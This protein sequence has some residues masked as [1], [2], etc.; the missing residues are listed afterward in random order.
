MTPRFDERSK[1]AHLS[2]G[3]GV[4]LLV[5]GTNLVTAVVLST[6]AAGRFLAGGGSG[7]KNGP[8]LTTCRLM[9]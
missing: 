6:N 7:R 4:R 2:R 9:L 5:L 3:I 8:W 1:L